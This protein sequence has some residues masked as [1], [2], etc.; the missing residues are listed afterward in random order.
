MKEI[1]RSND[2]IKLSWTKSMLEAYDIECFHFDPNSAIAEGSIGAIQQRIMVHDEDFDQ[3]L[4]ILEKE[5]NALE[6]EEE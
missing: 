6:A 3:A 5:M 2:L 4:S 1:L